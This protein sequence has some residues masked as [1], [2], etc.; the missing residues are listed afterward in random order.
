VEVSFVSLVGFGTS[1]D[2]TS[3]GRRTPVRNPNAIRKNFHR[4]V[5]EVYALKQAGK[6]MDISKLPNRGIYDAPDWIKDVKLQKLNNS[7][8]LALPETRTLDLLLNEMES[9]P[10]WVTEGQPQELKDE[11]VAEE[12]EEELL[13]EAPAPP[14][15]DPETPAHRRAALVKIDAE[16]RFD[17]MSNRPVPRKPPVEPIVENIETTKKT[18]VVEAK[19]ESAAKPNEI[20]EEAVVVEAQ[21]EPV[22][23]LPSQRRSNGPTPVTPSSAIIEKLESSSMAVEQTVA[24]LREAVRESIT[25]L[26]SESSERTVPVEVEAKWQ[27]MPLNDLDTKFAVS[28]SCQLLLVSN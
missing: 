4:A 17:F 1:A 12:E 15:M 25:T 13:V 27:S 2:T 6:N 26:T 19:V 21:V 3:Y 23:A 8:V 22:L 5:I 9:V 7:F 14:V 10:E 18:V 16:K 11:P 24:A 28:I 20:V